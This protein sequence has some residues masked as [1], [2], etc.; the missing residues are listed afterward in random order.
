MLHLAV[1]DLPFG[2]VG[3]SGT[4]SYHGKSGFDTFSHFKSVLGKPTRPDPAL[5]Y[6]PYT[7]TKQKII[8]KFM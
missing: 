4:G 1:P 8:R 2:G 5:M 6:P 7:A 3:E